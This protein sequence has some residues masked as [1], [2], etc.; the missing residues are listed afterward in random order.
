MWAGVGCDGAGA[1]TS[2]DL[3]ATQLTLQ[4]HVVVSL[5]D[6][7]AIVRKLTKLQ[8]LTLSKVGLSGV[9]DNAGHSRPGNLLSLHCM[10][11][12]HNPGITGEL[13][14]SWHNLYN[15]QTLDI[16]H[17]GVSGTLPDA[18]AALQQLR[19]FKVVNCTGISG[20]LPPA[21]G[22]LNLEVL[23]ITNSGLTGSLPREW[24]DAGA[25]RRARAAA[26]ATVACSIASVTTE[27]V[28]AAA[29]ALAAAGRASHATAGAQPA[30][31]QPGLLGML[32]L[33]VL[34][35]SMLGVSKGGLTGTLPGSF[36][37]MK[38]LQVTVSIRTCFCKTG[39][40]ALIQV[41]AFQQEKVQRSLPLLYHSAP[42]SAAV[43][44]SVHHTHACVIV[45]ASSAASIAWCCTS[46]YESCSVFG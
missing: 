17:T 28:D 19:E 8:S 12:S 4:T 27:A 11:L 41:A 35:L 31:D 9:L 43:S 38:Q 44:V 21:W 13:P 18:Y 42:N 15:L 7:V 1:V 26:A 20:Q 39:N 14:C 40:Y 2:L 46:L 25:L 16:S 30:A 10:D 24:A 36:A 32:Q 29:Q 37:A 45:H 3:T 34:D 23:E 33:R 6:V 5:P 22:L